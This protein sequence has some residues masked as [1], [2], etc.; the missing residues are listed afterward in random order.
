MEEP[1]L[2]AVRGGHAAAAQALLGCCAPG[3]HFWD[4]ALIASSKAGLV[5]LVEAL[6]RKVP[7]SH[8]TLPV[9]IACKAARR[10]GHAAIARMLD[11]WMT[12]T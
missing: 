10:R 1:F 3:S 12:T 8:H 11:A 5:D 9:Y 2:A 7:R 4:R 6:L